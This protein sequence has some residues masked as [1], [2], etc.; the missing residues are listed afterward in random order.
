MTPDDVAVIERLA[1]PLAAALLVDMAD[2]AGRTAE[3][4][5]I[6]GR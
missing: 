3:R 6:D 1:V 2:V 4:A 5:P